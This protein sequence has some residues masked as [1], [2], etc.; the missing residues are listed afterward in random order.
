M[1]KNTIVHEPDSHSY[2]KFGGTV[3]AFDLDTIKEACLVSGDQNGNETEVTEAYE[4]D[5]EEK[6]LSLSSK[7]VRDI[8]STGNPQNDMIIY[9]LVK[10]F[11]IRLLDN[12]SFETDV[13]EN[14]MDFSTALAI[15][16][17]LR[18]GML[19]EI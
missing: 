3:Y 1:V 16:T 9:D 18:W 19:V 8:K 15:N 13:K 4:M 11:I 10:L 2:I 5:E 14:G 6:K 17:L 7:I 12:S